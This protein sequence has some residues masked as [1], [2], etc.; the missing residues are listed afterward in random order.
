ME[1]ETESEQ[2]EMDL[3]DNDEFREEAIL[4]V[5]SLGSDREEAELLVEDMGL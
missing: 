4:A 1:P 2:M 5:M 3:I